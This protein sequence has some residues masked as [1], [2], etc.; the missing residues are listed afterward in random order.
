[1]SGRIRT[2]KPE[3]LEDAVVAG[4]SD[5]AFRLFVSMILM[6]D[7]Y[8]NFHAHPRQLAGK[9]FWDDACPSR[10]SREGVATMLETLAN[11]SL[12]VRYRVRGQEYAHLAGWEKHQRVDRP[13]K[14]R[15]PKPTDADAIPFA[16]L[17]DP[18]ETTAAPSRDPRETLAT[19]LRPPTS[20]LDPDRDVDPR[21][22]AREADPHTPDDGED[23]GPRRLPT[24]DRP[25]ALDASDILDALARG[26]GAAVD[27]RA[28]RDTELEFVRAVRESKYTLV[29]VGALGRYLAAG[30]CAWA[31][32]T[33]FDLAFL[34][35]LDRG[36]MRLT[37]LMTRALAWD[38]G[39]TARA[40]PTAGRAP[41]GAFGGA[42]MTAEA[43]MAEVRARAA[44]A[45]VPD[46]DEEKAGF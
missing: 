32:R 38:A 45:P 42:Q 39:E 21:A 27:I 30:Q 13:G 33:R 19:D 5:G 29:E 1:M 36:V 18:R 35:Q 24:V 20:D 8:G 2:L 43:T 11:A 3:M 14:P 28:P 41:R 10:D 34:T 40:P 9:A 26:G 25:N 23:T 6:A 46:A 15:V 12:L 7:D 17:R 31:K 37:E 44:A 16:A 22:G 4:L